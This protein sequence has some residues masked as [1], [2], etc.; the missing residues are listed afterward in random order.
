MY[1]LFTFESDKNL[2]ISLQVHL[3]IKMFN[4]KLTARIYFVTQ[5][6]TQTFIFNYQTYLMSTEQIRIYEN[7]VLSDN[8]QLL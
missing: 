1:K 2:H 8:R 5:T 4:S 6:H 3:N 7:L